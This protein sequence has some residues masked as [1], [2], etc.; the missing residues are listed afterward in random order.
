MKSS[1]VSR[2]LSIV[3]SRKWLF[4]SVLALYSMAYAPFGINETDGGFI[5]GLAW[6]VLSGKQ[7]F[8]EIIYVRPPLPI[9]FRAAELAVLPENWA[10]FAERI[11]F[12]WK[13]GLY[14]LLAAD[15]L[16]EKSRDCP[17]R[18]GAFF[19]CDFRRSD[20]GDDCHHQRADAR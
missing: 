2:Q 18:R 4:F 10:V 20:L 12:F 17:P 14:S 8:T 6:Q 3:N 9:W 5:T 15:I 11:L 1:I 16:V 19:T 13:I 7:L